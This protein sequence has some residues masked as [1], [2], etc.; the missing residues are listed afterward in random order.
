MLLILANERGIRYAKRL[1]LKR[2]QLILLIMFQRKTNNEKIK[3]FIENI[4]GSLN[5]ERLIDDTF[6]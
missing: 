3:E 2:I 4:N 1:G 6:D 5:L